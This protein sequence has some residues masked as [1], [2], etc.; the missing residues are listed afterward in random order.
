M[1]A[2]TAA[3]SAPWLRIIRAGSHVDRPIPNMPMIVEPA[4]T[5][6]AGLLDQII[7]SAVPNG[8]AALARSLL[9]VRGGS[10]TVRQSRNAS[11]RPGRPA[12]RKPARHPYAEATAPATEKPMIVPRLVPM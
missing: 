2:P 12:T 7:R 11:N 9:E 4:I 6:R 3:M 10:R 8:G 5:C 1:R